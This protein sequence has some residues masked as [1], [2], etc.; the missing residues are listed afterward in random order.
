MYV[1][2]SKKNAEFF[3]E[4]ESGRDEPAFTDF[5]KGCAQIAFIR[6]VPKPENSSPCRALQNTVVMNQNSKTD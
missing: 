1:V 2:C 5:Y 4:I 6:A 3:V